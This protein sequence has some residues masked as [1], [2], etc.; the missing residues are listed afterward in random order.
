MTVA[1]ANLAALDPSDLSLNVIG[2]NS[3]SSSQ[4]LSLTQSPTSTINRGSAEVQFLTPQFVS[5]ESFATIEISTMVAG[6]K[7]ST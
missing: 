3:I 1:V 4:V 6:S 5:E 7:M 2:A